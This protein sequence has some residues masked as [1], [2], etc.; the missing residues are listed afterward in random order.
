MGAISSSAGLPLEAAPFRPDVR[1]MLADIFECLSWS[2]SGLTNLTSDG[3][4]ILRKTI[5]MYNKH[6]THYDASIVNAI[7]K[8]DGSRVNTFR[9]ALRDAEG[10]SGPYDTMPYASLPSHKKLEHAFS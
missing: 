7:L 9:K 8:G 3:S 1:S 10:E 4:E 6:F 5:E 2:A